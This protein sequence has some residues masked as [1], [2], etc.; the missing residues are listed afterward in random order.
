MQNNLTCNK[1]THTHTHKKKPNSRG[2]TFVVHESLAENV[3]KLHFYSESWNS[4]Q[5]ISLF[6]M[7]FFISARNIL[8]RIQR[9]YIFYNN[10][11][12]LKNVDVD[13]SKILIFW[14]LDISKFTSLTPILHS[15]FHNLCN[16]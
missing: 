2:V 16:I 1:N 10:N 7:L 15:I 9:I 8:C 14:P 4:V 12:I 13:V 3:N 11:K 6:K 5:Y